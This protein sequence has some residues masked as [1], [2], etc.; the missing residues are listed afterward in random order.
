MVLYSQFQLIDVHR[1]NLGPP[2]RTDT[3]D[4]GSRH[5]RKFGRPG[6]LD[7]TERLW[8]VCDFV[9]GPAQ[10][11]VNG[12]AVGVPAVPGPF[13]ADITSLLQLRNEVVFMV[14]SNDPLGPV[15]LEVRPA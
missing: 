3:T 15:A 10:V 9:P 4:A 11:S 6:T 2:W 5:A 14:A 8:L 13:A 1:I 12:T 7:A